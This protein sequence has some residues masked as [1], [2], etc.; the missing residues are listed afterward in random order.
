MSRYS[1]A[2]NSPELSDLVDRALG[3]EEVVITRAGSPVVQLQVVEAGSEFP[4]GSHEWLHA[5]TMARPGIGISGLELLRLAREE[6][7]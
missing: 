3:G 4:V 1:V 5:R 2:A 7:I 6:E